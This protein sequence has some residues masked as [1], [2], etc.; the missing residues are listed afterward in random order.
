MCSSCVDLLTCR[1][2]V[3]MCHLDLVWLCLCT[4]VQI[5]GQVEFLLFPAVLFEVTSVLNSEQCDS[6]SFLFLFPWRSKL[7]DDRVAGNKSCYWGD[8]DQ[9]LLLT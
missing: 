4:V 9:P 7:F 3:C 8:I 1:L 6:D 5:T 2:V